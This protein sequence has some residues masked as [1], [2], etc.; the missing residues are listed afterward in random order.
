[1]LETDT[2]T[3]DMLKMSAQLDTGNDELVELP[4]SAQLTAAAGAVFAEP[5]VTA[6]PC[7]IK[8]SVPD[9]LQRI[10]VLANMAGED[11]CY[12]FPVKTK[13]GGKK[14]IEGPT[15]QLANDLAR[16]YMNNMV[17]V[18]AV[19]QPT[20]WLFYARFVDFE[21]GFCLTRAFKQRKG[22]KTMNTDA[23]RAEDIVFQIGQSKAIRNVV[24]NALQTFA[25]FSFRE[26]RKSLVTQIGADLPAWLDKMRRGIAERKFD[27]KRIE[28]AVGNTIDKWL[29][30]DVARVLAELKSIQDG[31]ATFDDI[32]PLPGTNISDINDMLEKEAKKPEEAKAPENPTN[33]ASAGSS[34]PTLQG[35]TTPVLSS[36][37][38]ATQTEC[39]HE[40]VESTTPGVEVCTECE[41]TRPA[42]KPPEFLNR[43]GK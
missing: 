13:E 27:L 8:R 2:K 4:Q 34:N 35:A 22:Q 21:T 28:A 29:A 32:Y 11:Y 31:M 39:P 16:E 18:R 15:I 40:W 10:K 12:R 36:G 43:N 20:C 24:V 5:I 30:P 23:E 26:A 9:F 37:N 6:Q 17:D 19:E 3:E 41:K 38:A 42:D 25:D 7:R 1:M 14:F 33:A